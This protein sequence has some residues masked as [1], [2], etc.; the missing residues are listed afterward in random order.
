MNQVSLLLA[1]RYLRAATPRSLK[2]YLLPSIGLVLVGVLYAI[3]VLA[4]RSHDPHVLGLHAEWARAIGNGKWLGWLT[5]ILLG[6]FIATI[7]RLTIFTT[8]STYGMFLGCAA[9]VVVMSVMSGFE[10]DIKRKILGTHAHVVVTRVDEAFTDWPARL[11]AIGKMPGVSA[12]TPYLSAEAMIA[13]SRN[14]S[15]V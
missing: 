8:I 3:D 4:R 7:R 1:L 6:T 11:A 10:D 14:R 15:N 5:V 2:L 13:S 12:V 9:L